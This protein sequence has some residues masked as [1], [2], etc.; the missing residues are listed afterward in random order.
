MT[1]TINTDYAP[2]NWFT[3]RAGH[4]IVAIVAHN[5]VGKDSRAYLKRG[6][7]L[8]DGS[9]LKVSIHV[10]IQKDGT[11]YR[12]L[13]DS[14]GANHAGFGK[15]P[16]GYPQVNPN[17][18]TLGFELENASNGAG[19]HD[20]YP[21]AQLTA[22]GWQIRAWRRIHGPLP[23]FR[24]ADLDPTRRKDT[25]DLSIAD[26]ERWAAEPP[27]RYRVKGLPVY[28]AQSGRGKL[29]GHLHE[30][31]QVAVDATYPNGFGHLVDG[32][33]FIDLDGLE[34]I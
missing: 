26:I 28:E 3:D 6:G 23:I 7:E 20:P 17:L 4:P 25:V 18:V 9:D 19:V 16:P 32:R 31:E 2:A 12:Y 24:H 33:G 22:M 8:P 30:G 1:P 11:I 27:R 5:T 14:A 21:V 29:W 15:M 10:L 34:R 13:S